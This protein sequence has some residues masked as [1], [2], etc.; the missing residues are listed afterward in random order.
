MSGREG[1][2]S[3]LVLRK[4]TRAIADAV[5]EQMTAY[6]TTLTPLLRP[7]AVFG[8]HID[9]G[10]REA[11]QKPAQ[12]LKELQ[13]LYEPLAPARPLNLRR[14]LMPPFAFANAGLE[15]TPV[16]YLHE[17]ESGGR[18]RKILVRRPLTWTLT[19]AGFG[20]AKLQALLDQRVRPPEELQRFILAYLLMHV[21]TTHQTG[22][23]QI[24][25]SLHFPV[26]MTTVPEFGD[27]PVTRIGIGIS[28]ARPPD[29]VVIES[30]ELTGMDAFEELVNVED[31]HRLRSPFRERLLE[32]VSSVMPTSATT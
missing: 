20:P 12:A 15:V 25:E 32:V 24:L 19:Y 17:V 28:T 1:V 22:L 16:E 13:E 18:S 9:G 5:R 7:E 31:I 6:L 27:L 23:A 3:L 11:N 30:A 29:G 21:V 14:E 8:E 26:S 10:R 2:Q 4:L